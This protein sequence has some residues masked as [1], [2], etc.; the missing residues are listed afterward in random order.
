MLWNV[1]AGVLT[2][3]GI[4][5]AVREGVRYTLIYDLD[6]VLREDLNEIHSLSGGG[7]YDWPPLRGAEPQGARARLSRLVRAV[8]RP[9]RAA[10][11]VEQNTPELPPLA[12]QQGG[13]TFHV[14]Q[15]RLAYRE[16]SR[17]IDEAS[18]VCVGCNE[19]FIARD[20]ERIDQLVIACGGAILLVVP[21]GGYLLAGRTTRILA[22][23]D[24]PHRPPATERAQGAAADSRHGGRARC[25]GPH[26]QRPARPPRRLPAA[27]ARLSGQRGTRAAHAVGRDSQQRRSGARQRPQRNER[28]IA[29]CSTTSSS[30]AR[31]CKRSSTSCCCS[32][33]PTPTA[34]SRHGPVSLDELVSRAIEM[35]QGVAEY[36]GIELVLRPLPRALSVGNRHHLRQV[37][38]NLLDN[39][40]KFAASRYP[41]VARRRDR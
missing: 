17:E 38:N 1:A 13:D 36:H 27:E 22:E 40:I 14:D 16:L 11:L 20:M 12:R 37:L 33:N 28:N 21:I 9:K 4:L 39:A 15:Y 18:A 34:C 25:A 5:I 19:R 32:R 10:D 3:L 29:S 8:L 35:F 30:N 6:Q 26:G 7:E 23:P 2:G 41:A 24:S 31:P